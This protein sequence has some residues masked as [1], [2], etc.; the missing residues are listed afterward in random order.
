[1]ET[2]PSKTSE[3]RAVRQRKIAAKKERAKQWAIDRRERLAT[4]PVEK[5][6]KSRAESKAVIAT[7]QSR[8]AQ[9]VK[10]LGEIDVTLS[11]IKKAY[12]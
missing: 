4:I 7:L 11:I 3:E 1:M 2:H 5:Q 8:Q 9:L 10:E 6:T 12:K